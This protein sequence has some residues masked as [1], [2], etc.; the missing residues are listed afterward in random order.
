MVTKIRKESS[1]RWRN[2]VEFKKNKEEKLKEDKQINQRHKK[3]QKQTQDKERE[4]FL[5]THIIYI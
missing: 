3:K 2:V 4:N 1:R 5:Q